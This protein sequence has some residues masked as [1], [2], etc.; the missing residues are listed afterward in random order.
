MI[1]V[2]IFCLPNTF[3]ENFKT[4]AVVPESCCPSPRAFSRMQA[5][6]LRQQ[7][8][9]S[10]SPGGGRGCLENQGGGSLIHHIYSGVGPRGTGKEKE[11]LRARKVWGKKTS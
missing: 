4:L 6:K 9:Y 10:R 11:I 1:I 7:V 2:R 5:T 3:L 8:I